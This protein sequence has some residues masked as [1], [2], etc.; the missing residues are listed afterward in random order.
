MLIIPKKCDSRMIN[1]A[2]RAFFTELLEAGVTI[3]QFSGGL[4]HTKSILI[5]EQLSL[6]GTVNLDIR[7]LWLNFEITV[8]IDSAEFAK[9]L[10]EIHDVYLQQTTLLTL[11]EWAKR[12]LHQHILERLFYFFSPF[13]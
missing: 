1:W 4:L 12:P 9:R 6:V 2:S 5:D 11:S 13:L 3:K 10:K 7:S 8:A